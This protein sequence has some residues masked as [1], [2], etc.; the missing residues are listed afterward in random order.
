MKR[1]SIAYDCEHCGNE[2]LHPV[3]SL[4][5]EGE[6]IV[7]LMVCSQLDFVCEKCGAEYGTGDIDV[8]EFEPPLD[9]RKS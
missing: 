6:L 2:M 8:M 3:T 7:P 9:D 4:G 5:D 1:Y